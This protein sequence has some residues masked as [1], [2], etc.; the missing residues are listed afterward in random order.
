MN[1]YSS[2]QLQPKG[3]KIMIRRELLL[4]GLDCA[5]CAAKIEAGVNKISGVSSAS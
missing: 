5:N 2:V 3:D 1:N 4:E